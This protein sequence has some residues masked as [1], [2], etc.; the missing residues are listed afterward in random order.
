MIF[1]K[2]FKTKHAPVKLAETLDAA[3]CGNNNLT[4]CFLIL[5]IVGF[6]KISEI[7]DQNF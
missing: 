1:I 4:L 6:W 7:L 2:K 5:S 3:S